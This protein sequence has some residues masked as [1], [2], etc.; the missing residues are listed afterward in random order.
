VQSLLT[1][2]LPLQLAVAIPLLLP[3]WF[4]QPGAGLDV[5]LAVAVPL[6]LPLLAP[7]A[8]PGPSAGHGPPRAARDCGPA[9]P[10]AAP[11]PSTGHGPPPAAR[12]GGPV[13]FP[14]WVGRPAKL[15]HF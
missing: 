2:R 3:L 15:M 14:A 13:L 5:V 4:G 10:A 7:A 8:A 11:G 6:L 1:P 9:P 12:G